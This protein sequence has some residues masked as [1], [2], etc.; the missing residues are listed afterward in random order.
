MSTV[1]GKNTSSCE[2]QMVWTYGC[3]SRL[4]SRETASL[5]DSLKLATQ[6]PTEGVKRELQCVSREPVEAFSVWCPL[7]SEVQK[8]T[9]EI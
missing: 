4:L 9:P 6:N 3:R 8:H 5:S 2:A 7:W 1:H